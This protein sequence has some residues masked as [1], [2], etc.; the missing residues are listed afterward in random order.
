L[1]KIFWNYFHPYIQLTKKFH[2]RNWYTPNCHP[3]VHSCSTFI[4]IFHPNFVTFI[5]VDVVFI[6]HNYFGISFI[7]KNCLLAII[8]QKIIDVQFSSI[9][10][11]SSMYMWKNIFHVIL[12]WHIDIFKCFILVVKIFQIYPFFLTLSCSRVHIHTHVFI[13]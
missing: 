1:S 8:I 7:P 3:K 4:Q 12:T 11:L 9:L 10:C 6:P 13:S 2:P 5:H